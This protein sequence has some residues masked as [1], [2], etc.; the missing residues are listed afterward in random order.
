MR[1]VAALQ[2][3][4]VLPKVYISESG[5]KTEQTSQSDFTVLV[6][7]RMY[8]SF[9]NGCQLFLG[10]AFRITEEAI[11]RN[12]TLLAVERTNVIYYLCFPI[13]VPH[14]FQTLPHY[15]LFTRM[16]VRAPSVL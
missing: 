13:I 5:D 6:L 16:L 9:V 10:F 12:F 2:M 4:C 8:S 3:S 14:L 15:L 11:T 7:V 1:P